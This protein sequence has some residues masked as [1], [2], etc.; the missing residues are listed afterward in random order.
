VKLPKLSSLVASH[1]PITEL[2]GGIS[3][4][5]GLL[6]LHMSNCALKAVPQVRFWRWQCIFG[7]GFSGFFRQQLVEEWRLLINPSAHF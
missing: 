2:P 3:K 5:T 6:D 4:L 7:Q 1:N